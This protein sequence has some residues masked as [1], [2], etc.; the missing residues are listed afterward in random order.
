MRAHVATMGLGL[1]AVACTRHAPPERATELRDS[2]PPSVVVVDAGDDADERSAARGDGGDA[3]DR[4]PLSGFSEHFELLDGKDKL[5]F[6]S[7]PLGAREPR[8][9]MI[10]IH[11]GS[12]KPSLACSAWRGITEAY[13][14]VV[15]PR[16]WGGNESALG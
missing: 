6:V 11:G 9:I 16:G 13:P 1:F 5:G 10:A 14:F 3:G 8:P 15:C 2:S 12:D 4:A 7:V